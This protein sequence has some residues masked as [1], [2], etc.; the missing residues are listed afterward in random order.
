MMLYCMK[1]KVFWRE[2]NGFGARK[3][4]C[5]DNNLGCL[6]GDE[7]DI[8][9][10]AGKPYGTFARQSSSLDILVGFGFFKI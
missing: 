7:Q 1:V 4:C 6:D 8:F 2:E 3:L 9:K 10:G 5:I